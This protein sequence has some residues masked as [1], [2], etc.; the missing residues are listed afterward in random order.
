MKLSEYI[1]QELVWVVDDPTSRDLILDDISKRIHTVYESIN[2]DELYKALLDREAKGPTAVPEGVAFPHA[3]VE[4]APECFVAAVVNK[5]G[6]DFQSNHCDKVHVIFV[7]VGNVQSG[8]Q[9][10]RLLARLARICHTPGAV[11]RLTGAADPQNLY[12]ILLEED[13]RHV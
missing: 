4:N 3:L 1:K 5:G 8:W 9:H 11:N 12:D 7:L 6:V 10:V 2:P 13:N